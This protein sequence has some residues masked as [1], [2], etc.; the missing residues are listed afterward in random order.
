MQGWSQT[1]APRN[2]TR[3]AITH[4]SM[5]NCQRL[6]FAL[7]AVLLLGLCLLMN[8]ERMRTT[9]MARLEKAGWEPYFAPPTTHIPWQRRLWS[10]LHQEPPPDIFDLYEQSPDYTREVVGVSA[11]GDRDS[12]M[13]FEAADSL[14]QL[15]G[16]QGVFVPNCQRLSADFFATLSA[17]P[18]LR[19]LNL[20]GTN[21]TDDMLRSFAGAPMI[22]SITFVVTTDLHGASLDRFTSLKELVVH[23]SHF[24]DTGVRALIHLSHLSTLDLCFTH[25]TPEALTYLTDMKSLRKLHLPEKQFKDHPKLEQFR[26]SRPDVEVTLGQ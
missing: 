23:D 1:A 24:D 14:K 9:A 13:K 25:I 12:K 11:G 16:I 20:D 17:L 2:F 21:V 22:E 6:L 10:W 7:I 3:H 15:P 18:N 4:G 19:R 8:R 5:K 26:A